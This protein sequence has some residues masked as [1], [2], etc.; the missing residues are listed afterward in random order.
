[1]VSLQFVPFF[2]FF[3]HSLLLG[4]STMTCLL[5]LHLIWAHMSNSWDI[6]F[7]RWLSFFINILICICCFC[8]GKTIFWFSFLI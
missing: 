8:Y 1:L 2:S 3:N 6:E 5:N 7:F 4:F